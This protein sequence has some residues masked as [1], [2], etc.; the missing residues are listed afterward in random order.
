VK[1][2]SL[3]RSATL[4]E[5]SP[6]FKGRGP[7]EEQAETRY[8]REDV[9]AHIAADQRHYDIL[10]LTTEP[11]AWEDGMRTAGGPGTFEWWYFDAEYGDGTKIVAIFFSK[12]RFDVAGDARPTVTLAITYPD[13]RKIV[14][15]ESE[16]FGTPLRAARDKARVQIKN[17]SLEYINGQ[18]VVH[19]SDGNI[20]YH[21][22]MTP[23]APMWRPNTGHFYFGPKE[24]SYFAWFVAQP[25]ANVTATL[26]IGNNTVTLDGTG[27]HDHN[28]GN[29]PM[30][31]LMNHWYWSRARLG[32]YT[33]IACDI[34][35][36]KKY[37]YS[38]IPIF[39]LAKHGKIIDDDASNTTI[40]RGDT[41]LHPATGKFMD[42]RL[43]FTQSCGETTY[44]VEYV[45][46]E[47]MMVMN[48]LDT[49]TPIKRIVAKV[50]GAK[51]TYVRIAGE[52][53]LTILQK[54][55]T[56]EEQ[57][58]SAIWEQMFFDNNAHAT[59]NQNKY[60]GM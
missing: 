17:S 19:F 45:R 20:E 13:G 23:R 40:E 34:I 33:V 4:I 6:T 48:L 41:F 18:Y 15:I 32:D 25:D 37:N 53:R 28:W 21:S 36:T 8:V 44:K 49:L 60:T 58:S 31:K 52:S 26:S 56:Q 3:P 5:P 55:H 7:H 57:H 9:V 27:Y 12:N 10:G 30:H 35:A 42:N 22:V 16:A 51:P 47:D 39:M 50:L 11:A 14:S 54:G 59:I 24:D 43:T 2:N 38:R 46:S 29:T 1:P